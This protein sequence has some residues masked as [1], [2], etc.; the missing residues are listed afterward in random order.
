MKRTT[1]Y[2]YA[3]CSATLRRTLHHLDHHNC[4][5][6]APDAYTAAG[7]HKERHIHATQNLDNPPVE[8]PRFIQ[9]TDGKYVKYVGP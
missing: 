7:D 1:K 4:H 2:Q 3:G 6:P 9:R 5:H 8:K